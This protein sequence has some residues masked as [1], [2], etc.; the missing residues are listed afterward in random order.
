M[1]VGARIRTAR[2]NANLTQAQLAELLGVEQPTVSRWER[3]DY[4]PSLRWL[5]EIARAT[6]TPL[7]W[8]LPE[9]LA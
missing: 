4:Q 6:E 7:P 2:E 3:D 1:E 9:A 5:A 8:F